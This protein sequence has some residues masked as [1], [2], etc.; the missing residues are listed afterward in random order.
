VASYV[1]ESDKW[2]RQSVWNRAKKGQLDLN[3]L[4][5]DIYTQM[6][7]CNYLNH[8]SMISGVGELMEITSYMHLMCHMC[9]G[10][11]GN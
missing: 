5:H 10:S 3:Y 7:P 2:I 6:E 9:L 11:Q 1:D 4:H 8:G